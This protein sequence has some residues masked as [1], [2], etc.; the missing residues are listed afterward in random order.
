MKKNQFNLSY[1]FKDSYN[2]GNRLQ[3]EQLH[4]FEAASDFTEL[5]ISQIQC[6]AVAKSKTGPLKP[7]IRGLH[8]DASKSPFFLFSA[9]R[10]GKL[11]L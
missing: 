3:S 1:W 2:S 9:L 4:S 6:S 8:C 10:E 5:S 7:E 11:T